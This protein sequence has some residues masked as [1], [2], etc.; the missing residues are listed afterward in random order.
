MAPVVV[1]SDGAALLDWYP[2]ATHPQPTPTHQNMHGYHTFH[3]HTDTL[4]YQQP[5]KLLSDSLHHHH[6]PH[7]NHLLQTSHL[8]GHVTQEQMMPDYPDGYTEFLDMDGGDSPPES[9]D[10]GSVQSDQDHEAM[11]TLSGEHCDSNGL[12]LDRPRKRRRRGIVHVVQQRHAANMR[13]RKR[14]QSINEAFEGLRAHIPTLPYE[15]RLS[16]VDT[17]RLAIGYISFLSELV[18]SDT[19]TKNNSRGG[20]PEQPRKII[21]HCHAGIFFKLRS[22]GTHVLEAGT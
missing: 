3:P 16:K 17:L 9:P 5:L 8:H 13:E 10:Y 12:L 1:R 20:V 2:T 19:G 15:K 7:H 6:L 18:A 11:V 4:H 14:M 22:V 21:I